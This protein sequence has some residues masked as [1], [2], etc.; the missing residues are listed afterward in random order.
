MKPMQFSIVTLLLISILLLPDAAIPDY[1]QWHLPEGVKARLGKGRVS[2]NVAFSPDNHLLAVA[3]SIGIWIYDVHTMEAV[4][5]LVGHTSHVESIAFSPDG[6]TLASAG[7]DSTVRLWDVA[8]G[9]HRMILTGHTS[10]VGSVV[11]S[12]DGK[13][14]ASGAGYWDRTLQLWDIATGEPK[15]D[16]IKFASAVDAIAFSPDGHLLA[17][18]SDGIVHLWHTTTLELEAT[19][20]RD[21]ND[22]H[23]DNVNSVAFSPDGNTLATGNWDDTVCL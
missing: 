13:T 16:P 21:I 18:V 17:S 8:T 22:E 12:P 19:F 10:W 1:T 5:L 20:D 9:T 4:N 23:T 7:D 2:G 3:S 14:L 15:A 11:F 6:R